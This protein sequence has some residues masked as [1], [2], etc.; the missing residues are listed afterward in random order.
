[1]EPPSSSS[2]SSSKLSFSLP[3]TNKRPSSLSSNSN[4]PFEETNSSSQQHEFVT[5]FDPSKTLT[6]HQSTTHV[7]PR[8]EN[9]W[10]PYKKMKNLDIPFRSASDDPDLRFELE[11]PNTIATDSSM[12]YGLNIRSNGG[13][14]AGADDKLKNSL[15]SGAGAADKL[16]Q[17]QQQRSVENVILQKYKE[18]MK[19][20]PDDRGLEE[21]DDVPVE[22]FG[23]ALLKSYGWSEGK[24]IGKN[25]K[26]DVKVVQYVRRADKEGLGFQSSSID[27]KKPGQKQHLV[28]PRGPDGKTRHVVGIDEKLVPRELKGIHVGKIV[29]VVSGR[30]IGLKGKVLEKYDS[31]SSSSVMV[32]LKL[33][34]SDE[35]VTVGL[36]EVAELGSVDEEL[37]LEDLKMKDNLRRMERRGSLSHREEKKMNGNRYDKETV[38]RRNRD[39]GG[40]VKQEKYGS[41]TKHCDNKEKEKKTLPV[42]WLASHI[43]VRIISKDLKGGKLYLKKGEV[44][45]V[46]GPGTCDI[47][48]DESKELIQGVNQDILETAVPKPG[49]PVLILYGK[50]KGTF[51]YLVERNMEKETGVV[52][53]AD[54]HALLNVRLEQI[55]EYIGDPSCIGY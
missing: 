36:K 22:G 4:F 16:Q 43:R 6:T 28:A 40:S 35:E 13:G 3:S 23:I 55:A 39:E 41:N 17:Q 37:C 38:K 44:L 29:R 20:L 54:S 52:Q 1:M 53:D 7:I 2:S 48:L 10:N 27:E 46:V 12:A 8:L 5:E 45:D 19:I 9:T 11:A 31:H 24:G 25:A 14:G 21:F 34:R 50:H 26:E 30:H 42:S 51:G 47:S 33:I 49:G 18:D 32:V 15:S